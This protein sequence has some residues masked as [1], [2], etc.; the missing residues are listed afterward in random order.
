MIGPW[1]TDLG[2]WGPHA[3]LAWWTIAVGTVVNSACAILGCFLVLRKLSLLGDAISHAVL[4]GIVVAFL[5]AGRS[6]FA[7]LFLGALVT[8]I[9]TTFF[10]QTLA[11]FGGVGEDAGMGVVFTA[12]FSI[13]VLLLTR[14]A[15]DVH[16]DAS[17]IIFGEIEYIPLDL[18][19]VAG[20]QV[21]RVL[22]SMLMA[23][24]LTVSFVAL[25][26]KE[27]KLASF[28]PA[29]AV[30][31]GYSATLLHY[32]LMIMTAVVTVTAFEAVGSILVVAMLVVPPATAYLLTDRLP[33]MIF[34]SVVV[35]VAS[36]F[37]GYVAAVVWQAN[38]AGMTAVAAGV[39]FT[40]AVLLAPR[41]GLISKAWNSW[42]LSIR[43]VGE[44][45]AA[46]L[47]RDEEA[48]ARRPGEGIAGGELLRRAGGGLSAR[49]ALRQL[50]DR[51]DLTT[52][53]GSRVALTPQGRA[54]AESLVRSHRL[55]ES[56]LVENFHL[57]LDHLHDPAEKIEHFIGPELQ[58][59]LAESLPE[60]K[61]DPHGREIPPPRAP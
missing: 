33:R 7:A 15:R 61:R 31:L 58:K 25:F 52:L 23:L 44:D 46:A 4:P 41:Y 10:I 40:L 5:F 42:R 47:F 3:S 16:L 17:C 28:D 8:G 9:L 6:S 2:L 57:P 27:L 48:G 54:A 22:P 13:G 53:D 20:F 56:Y 50:V 29:L 51:G 37:L 18:I 32:L 11:R 34:W 14:L 36:S 30:S 45:L 26:W 35:A 21:P 1:L 55:W 24:V 19:R 59:E 39:Q 38:V 12:L 49:F 43:I 60:K